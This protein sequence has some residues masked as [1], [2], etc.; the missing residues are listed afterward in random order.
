[1]VKKLLGEK[2]GLTLME[3]LVVISIMMLMSVIVI[4]NYR[5][6]QKQIDVDY[7]VEA[8]EGAIREAQSRSMAVLNGENHGVYFDQ[9]NNK[10]YIFQGTVFDPGAEA[11]IEYTLA[12]DVEFVSVNFAVTGDTVVFNQLSGSTDNSGSMV[13][14][15]A[16]ITD[17][18]RTI[19]IT[20]E[21]K[22]EI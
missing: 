19:T 4:P 2:I 16:S 14:R 18:Q 15:S 11:N 22:V 20:K 7:E 10:Y 9:T 1:M 17:I 3:I 13:V 6:W 21:G 8:L 5:R 12:K